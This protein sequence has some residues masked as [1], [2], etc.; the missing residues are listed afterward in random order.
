MKSP[1][2][3]IL[4]SLVNVCLFI[5]CAPEASD[6]SPA[7][8]V[9]NTWKLAEFT[10]AAQFPMPDSVRQEIIEKTV[11]EY[12]ADKKFKQ[13]GIGRT[14]TGTYEISADGKRITYHHDLRDVPFTETVLELTDK[15]MSVMDQNGN[16]MVRVRMID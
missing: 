12:T 4:I 14:H 5:H 6:D 16:R 7:S 2:C 3:L 10:P 8:L 11:M 9:I 15:R 1:L 13:T